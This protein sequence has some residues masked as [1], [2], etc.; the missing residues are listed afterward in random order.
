MAPLKASHL[1]IQY[2]R[3]AN[4][5]FAINFSGKSD[6]SIYVNN[7]KKFHLFQLFTE[8]T[9]RN[10]PGNSTTKAKNLAKRFPGALIIGVMKG[11]T[12]EFFETK[13]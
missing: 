2:L 12:S 7:G 5:I 3:N 6:I 9:M 10:N 13:F 8:M 4:S 11:G 1:F